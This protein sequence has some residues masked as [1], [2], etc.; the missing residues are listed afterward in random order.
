MIPS[1]RSSASAC[2]P[3]AQRTLDRGRAALDRAAAA[4]APPTISTTE[5]HIVVVHEG[6]GVSY[7]VVKA[8]IATVEEL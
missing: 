3:A 7:I 6:E 1:C 2:D 5:P 4:S 8:H